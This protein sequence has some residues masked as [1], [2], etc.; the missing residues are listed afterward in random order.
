MMVW[1]KPPPT[2]LIFAVGNTNQDSNDRY[3]IFL[4]PARVRWWLHCRITPPPD[5]VFTSLDGSKTL[6]EADVVVPTLPGERVRCFTACSRGDGME[7]AFIYDSCLC[8]LKRL[9]KTTAI[10]KV[11]CWIHSPIAPPTKNWDGKTL[12]GCLLYVSVAR[13][14]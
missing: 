10:D 11:R 1:K 7:K 13:R 5:V 6:I 2:A 14:C 9:T 12:H 3:H 8:G 4:F